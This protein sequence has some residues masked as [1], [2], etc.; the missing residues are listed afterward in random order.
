MSGASVMIMAGGTGGHVF[1]GLAVAKALRAREQRVV[2]LGTRRGLEARVVPEHGIDIQFISIA[3]IRGKRLWAWLTAP[4]RIAASVVQALTI[5]RRCR[6]DVVL[7]MGGFVAGP[8]GVAAW[9]TRRPLVIHEQNAVAGTT[10]R[11]LARLARCVFEGFPGSFGGGRAKTI[12]NPVRDSIAAVGAARRSRIESADRAHLLV[13][14]GSQGALAINELVPAALAR[15]EPAERPMVRHQ[16]GRT[17]ATARTAYARFGVAADLEEFIDDMA[18]AYAWADLVVARAG[19][20]TVAELTAAG[21]GAILVP[22]PHAIDDHQTRNA[23]AFVAAGAGV[24]LRQAGLDPQ[25]LAA[26]LADCLGDRRRLE[27]MGS[28][29]LAHALPDAAD[30]IA[31]ACVA[32]AEERR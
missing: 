29:A 26:A 23:E 24:M 27:A 1:P 7:G 18:A 21:V 4:F 19:A 22:L 6:P 2:W 11:L 8:G 10:N 12:G 15:L 17:L 9:L 5:L 13:L 3:G 14:G 30:K 32:L 28:A 31:A 25:T 20:L 16:G